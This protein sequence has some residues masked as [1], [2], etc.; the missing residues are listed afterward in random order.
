MTEH[1]L[2]TMKEIKKKYYFYSFA[3]TMGPSTRY[4]TVEAGFVDLGIVTV[5]D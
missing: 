3:N 4:V 1:G 5:P 2:K